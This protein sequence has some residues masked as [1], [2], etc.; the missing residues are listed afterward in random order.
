MGRIASSKTDERPV[1]VRRLGAKASFGRNMVVRS[2]PRVRRGI[3]GE[4]RRVK[5][6]GMM[7]GQVFWMVSS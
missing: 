7:S 5:S 1:W 6:G 2:R 4:S 3:D